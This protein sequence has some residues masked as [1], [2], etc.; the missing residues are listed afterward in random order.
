MMLLAEPLKMMKLMKVMKMMKLMMMAL[1]MR[2]VVLDSSFPPSSLGGS[3]CATCQSVECAGLS[4]SVF[5]FVSSANSKGKPQKI[6]KRPAYLTLLH[7]SRK[8]ASYI[9]ALSSIGG[10]QRAVNHVVDQS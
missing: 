6:N 3:S 5:L 7:L 9:V 8:P 2:P 4:V 10:D 1:R